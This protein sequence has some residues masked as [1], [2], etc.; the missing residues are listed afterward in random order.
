MLRD[1]EMVILK[2]STLLVQLNDDLQ[3]TPMVSAKGVH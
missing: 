1:L 3:D 2:N